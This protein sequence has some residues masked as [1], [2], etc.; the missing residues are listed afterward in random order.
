MAG[1]YVEYF[2]TTRH[3]KNLLGS[4]KRSRLIPAVHGLRENPICQ[5]LSIAFKIKLN[6]SSFLF[7]PG[8]NFVFNLKSVQ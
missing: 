2:F 4:L 3:M 6:E 5:T 8:K 1:H 7:V